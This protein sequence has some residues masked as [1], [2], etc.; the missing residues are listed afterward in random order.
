[1]Y[2]RQAVRASTDK[3]KEG[4]ENTIRYL[5]KYKIDDNQL[6]ECEINLK[7]IETLVQAFLKV[8][9]AAYHERIQYPK[10]NRK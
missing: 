5:I 4:I 8:L 9:K 7:D 1:M 6:Y 2:K 10:I 3:S